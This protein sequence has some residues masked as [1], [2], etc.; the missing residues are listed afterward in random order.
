VIDRLDAVA[1]E[2]AAVVKVEEGEVLDELV[3]VLVSIIA[4]WVLRPA[5]AMCNLRS[6]DH[7]TK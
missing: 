4:L 3:G 7:W 5:K 2:D 6:R 1:P